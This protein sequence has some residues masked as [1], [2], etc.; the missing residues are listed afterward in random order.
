VTTPSPSSYA[1]GKKVVEL[2]KDEGIPIA[3]EIRNMSYY[4]CPNCGAIHRIFQSSEDYLEIPF[5][6][7]IPLVELQP[8]G[9]ILDTDFP[10]DKILQAIE[11]PLIPERKSHI[12]RELLKQLLRVK[13]VERNT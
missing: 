4:C 3:G 5:I 10:I 1:D 7:E 11:N 6:C 9:I 8:G 2:F 12:K 13:H